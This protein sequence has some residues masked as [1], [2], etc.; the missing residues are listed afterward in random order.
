MKNRILI[1]V[2]MVALLGGCASA[3][4][5]SDAPPVVVQVLASGSHSGVKDQ[6]Y[7]DLHTAGDFQIWWNKA[8]A[9]YSTAPALPQVDFTKDMVIAAFM[10]EKS[11]GGYTLDIESVQQTPN[12]YNVLVRITI[13]GDYCHT[14]Q[15][16]VQPFEFVV[17]PNNNGVF[18]NWNVTQSRKA[19]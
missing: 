3:D 10:G 6:E 13:P 12:A 15:A 11:H 5:A 7:H 2:S 9:T 16:L 19:C 8:Y 17:V 1:A 4:S 18:I 14:T